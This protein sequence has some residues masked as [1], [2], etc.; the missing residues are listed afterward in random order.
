MN[1]NAGEIAFIHHCV[2]LKDLKTMILLNGNEKESNS[3]DIPVFQL[4]P[5]DVI[6]AGWFE[7]NE[8]IN[9]SVRNV[10]KN[11]VSTCVIG[12]D[13]Y[14]GTDWHKIRE[15]LKNSFSEKHIRSVFWNVE[16][17]RLSEK[18]LNDLLQPY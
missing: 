2:I 7:I 15:Q 1:T 8:F 17:C 14:P 4:H 9:R 12:I 6:I 5:D 13:G 18:Q 11:D 16:E 3:I 10:L